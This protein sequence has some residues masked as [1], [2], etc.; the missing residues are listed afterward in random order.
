M[1]SDPYRKQQM[2]H[3]SNNKLHASTLF[4]LKGTQAHTHKYIAIYT[5]EMYYA[6]ENIDQCLKIIHDVTINK[7]LIINFTI[8]LNNG[9]L[10]H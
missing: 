3:L 8:S 6:P 1:H 2:V 10:H 9:L 5:D 7:H 4:L